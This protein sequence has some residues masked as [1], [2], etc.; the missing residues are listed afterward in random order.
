ME[1]VAI[2]TL[3]GMTGDK[4]MQ[5]HSEGETSFVKYVAMKIEYIADLE[6]EQDVVDTCPDPEQ[7]FDDIIPDTEH[8]PE[9]IL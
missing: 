9:Q 3:K 5:K 7:D 4:T 2:H 8:V 1:E 6:L